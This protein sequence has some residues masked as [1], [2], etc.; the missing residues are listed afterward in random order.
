MVLSRH[1]K[2]IDRDVKPQ[3]KPLKETKKSLDDGEYP[4]RKNDLMNTCFMKEMC[5][6]WSSV[7]GL[8]QYEPDSRSISQPNSVLEFNHLTP[9]PGA[10]V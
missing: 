10:V 3:Y 6:T 7:Y 1:D 9:K 2:T 5:R 4:L 8:L